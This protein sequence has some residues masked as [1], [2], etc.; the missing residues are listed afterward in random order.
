MRPI[1]LSRQ[2]RPEHGLFPG[3][4]DSCHQ[5]EGYD[6]AAG[7][8]T[9]GGAYT[10]IRFGPTPEAHP[11]AQEDMR[12]R[13]HPT[14]NIKPWLLLDNDELFESLN[15]DPWMRTPSSPAGS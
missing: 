7:R 11:E 9:Q 14:F 8:C 10:L 3:Q 1:P 6:R 15:R 5:C 4:P 13:I 12:D 2:G